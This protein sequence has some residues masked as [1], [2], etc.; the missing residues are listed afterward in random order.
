MILNFHYE[1]NAIATI[2]ART[3]EITVPFGVIHSKGIELENFEEK[4]TFSYKVNAGIYVLNPNVLSFIKIKQYLD[5]PDLLNEVKITG[6]KVA[7]CPIYENWLDIGRP[8]T[9]VQA[10]ESWDK[11]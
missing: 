4:P 11:Y 9:Y 8:E 2:C 3:H 10:E 1:N 5:M 7:V 6:S